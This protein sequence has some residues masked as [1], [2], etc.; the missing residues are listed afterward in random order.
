MRTAMLLALAAQLASALKSVPKPV[1]RQRRVA[2]SQKLEGRTAMVFAASEL[3]YH[4][5]FRHI[6]WCE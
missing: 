4:S 2:L 6:A 3:D 5:T 1:Y